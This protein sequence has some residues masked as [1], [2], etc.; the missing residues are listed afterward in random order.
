MVIMQIQCPKLRI[1]SMHMENGK[2]KSASEKHRE[3]ENVVKITG[4]T[5]GILFAH[6]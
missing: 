5:Q 4:E 3:F 6:V 2:K 1:F